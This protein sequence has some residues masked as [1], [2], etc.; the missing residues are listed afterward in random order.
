[1]PNPSGNNLRENGGQK[2]KWLKHLVRSKFPPEADKNGKYSAF[3]TAQEKRGGSSRAYV[4]KVLNGNA[5]TNPSDDLIQIWDSFWP[6]YKILEPPERKYPKNPIEEWKNRG[7]EG[8]LISVNFGIESV[9]TTVKLL[10]T[11]PP[12]TPAKKPFDYFVEIENID[13]PWRPPEG[14]K[15]GAYENH[16]LNAFRNHQQNVN[17]DAYKNQN[18]L[19]HVHAVNCYDDKVNICVRKIS[20]DDVVATSS[21]S[22]EEEV[23]ALDYKGERLVKV[24]DWLSWA[25]EPSSEMPLPPAANNLHINTL[26]VSSDNFVIPCQNTPERNAKYVP[27]S[28]GHVE[29]NDLNRRDRQIYIRAYNETAEEVG[30]KRAPK[31]HSHDWDDF[32]YLGFVVGLKTCAFVLLGLELSKLTAKEIHD[33]FKYRINKE[34]GNIF[35]DVPFTR[36]GIAKWLPGRKPMGYMLLVHFELALQHFGK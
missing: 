35:H 33:G 10:H 5:N 19:L 2:L 28:H 17:P 29:V 36:K 1:M 7:D 32:R 14:L 21:D 13:E 24:I 27:T 25:W 20:Y 18:G 4:I 30:Y 34:V 12:N 26:V 9:D 6:P 22:L 16:R 31:Y 15:P 23:A 8:G 3:I 11:G